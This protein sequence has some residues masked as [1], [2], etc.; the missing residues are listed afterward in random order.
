MS[1]SFEG[2]LGLANVS[3]VGDRDAVYQFVVSGSPPL[4]AYYRFLGEDRALVTHHSEDWES[5]ESLACASRVFDLIEERIDSVWGTMAMVAGLRCDSVPM[6]DHVLTV[7]PAVK[8]MSFFKEEH[9]FVRKRLYCAPANRCEFAV[10]ESKPEFLGRQNNGFPINKWL[11]QPLPAVSTTFN[12]VGGP[13]SVQRRPAV[14]LYTDL[15]DYI[16][17]SGAKGGVVVVENFEREG[18]TFESEAPN[19]DLA[20]TFRRQTHEL[21]VKKALEFLDVLVRQGGDAAAET[22]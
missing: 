3:K 6:L 7:P 18:C 22:L 14:T 15:R 21:P 13:T 9:K 17:A 4:R 16:T 20:V 8:L 19:T 12:V 5:G 1:N 2:F 11:R 10:G